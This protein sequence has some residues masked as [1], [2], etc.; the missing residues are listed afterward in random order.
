MRI[1]QLHWPAVREIPRGSLSLPVVSTDKHH[2]ARNAAIGVEK[3]KLIVRQ[4]SFPD[5]RPN[6]VTIC[7]ERSHDLI[8]VGSYRR[9]VIA[10]QLNLAHV[11][12][13]AAVARQVFTQRV[14][15]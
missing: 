10:L 13:D 4:A 8:S 3:L 6:K 14:A 9:E 2:R 11:M 5:R 7:S 1:Q 12:P 15:R